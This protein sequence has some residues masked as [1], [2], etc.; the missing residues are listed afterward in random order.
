MTG[1]LGQQRIL[2][3]CRIKFAVHFAA[4]IQEAETHGLL[5]FHAGTMVKDGKFVTSGGRVLAVVSVDT[6]LPSASGR[7]VLGAT[8]I[9][10]DGA[11][12]R[13]D[14]GYHVLKG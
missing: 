3:N 1:A 6:D 9:K 4:G 11:F 8:S 13:K 12:F 7:A 5:V 14:I 10:F 2:R